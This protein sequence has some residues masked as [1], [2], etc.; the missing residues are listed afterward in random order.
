[1]GIRKV[2]RQAVFLDRDGV[3][4]HSI[5]RDGKPHPP[6]DVNE[7]RMVEDAPAALA[8]LK[9]AGFLL[10]VVTNQPDIARGV[11]PRA[12]VDAV[13]AAL[14]AV[15]PV[16]DFFVCWH[17]D[18]NRCECRKPKPGLLLEAAAKYDI[19]LAQSFLI[20][21]RWRDIDAG[22]AAGCRIV[23]IEYSYREREPAHTPDYRTN[24]L[25]AAAAWIIAT[26]AVHLDRKPT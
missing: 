24:S 2:K 9:E 23:L 8:R 25:T 5:I 18:R 1:M 6:S 13:N 19:D 17:D 21:D 3:L 4:N 10:I 20:G 22:A 11:T 14:G 15:L 12:A 16:D 26:S 7:L